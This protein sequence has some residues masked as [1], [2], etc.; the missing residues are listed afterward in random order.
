[1]CRSYPIGK[2]LVYCDHFKREMIWLDCALARYANL[3][4]GI[5]YRNYRRLRYK[6]I[7][8]IEKNNPVVQLSIKLP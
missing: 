3:Y 4:Q 6:K 8:S 7:N 1:M 5:N 2:G